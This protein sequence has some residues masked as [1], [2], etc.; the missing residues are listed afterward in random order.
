MSRQRELVPDLEVPPAQHRR[1]NRQHDSLVPGLLRT[2]NQTATLLLVLEQVQLKH[3][4]DLA[5]GLAHVFKRARRETA[6]PHRYPF[7]PAR[8]CR[9]YL[10]VA[11]REALHCCRRDAQRDRVAVAEDGHARVDL[12]DVAQYARPDAVAAVRG[13]VFCEGAPGVRPFVVV[14]PCLLVHAVP[15]EA[16]EFADR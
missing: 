3:I 8:P 7:R 2:L 12:R 14:V 1:I 15:R 16:L 10:A 6:Q 13:L 9:C 4:R 5:A 11:V